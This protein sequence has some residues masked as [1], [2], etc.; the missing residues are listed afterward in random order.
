MR[1]SK[2]HKIFSCYKILTEKLTNGIIFMTSG[3]NDMFCLEK[4]FKVEF[5]DCDPMGVVWNGKY[6]DYFE[7]AR[8]EL[9]ERMHLNYMSIFKKGYML[10][11]TRNKIKYIRPLSPGQ[12]V[13]IRIT[14]VEYEFL[15]KFKYEII[16]KKTGQVTTKGESSQMVTDLEGKGTGFVP[17]FITDA[18]KE[19]M[20]GL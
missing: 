1:Y 20:K 9:L 3:V 6:F 2:T 5:N 11:L 15:L 14:V 17:D 10:P 13:L 7:M 4:E 8:S 16:D 19:Y 18:F 12:R